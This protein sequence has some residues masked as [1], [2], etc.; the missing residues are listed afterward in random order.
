MKWALSIYVSN[1]V[2]LGNYALPIELSVLY[3]QLKA[4]TE[5]LTPWGYNKSDFWRNLKYKDNP[6][7]LNC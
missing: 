5:N 6:Q 2:N 1:D 4:R 3:E 7:N